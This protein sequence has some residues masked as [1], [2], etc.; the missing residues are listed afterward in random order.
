MMKRLLLFTLIGLLT[1]GTIAC[2]TDTTAPEISNEE[3]NM[4]SENN[5]NEEDNTSKEDNTDESED[6]ASEQ[7][8]E[9]KIATIYFGDSDAMGLNGEERTIEAITPETLINELIKGPQ[10]T[11]NSKTIPEGTK[12]L[13][14][15]VKDR[16]AY[17]NF[18][19]ELKDN[20]WG[21]SSGETITIYSIV[22]TLVLQPNLE[23]ERVQILVEGQ[24]IETL[25]GH[26]DTSVPLEPNL[27][28]VDM[29]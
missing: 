20:H 10:D 3:D 4:K 12:L 22:N 19:K 23:I 21:G 26:A 24:A 8:P 28:M 9:N 5:A 6:N 18:S 7:E 14:V 1:L 13:G 27:E 25:A 2:Q 11:N 15:E 29:K 16:I 17:V